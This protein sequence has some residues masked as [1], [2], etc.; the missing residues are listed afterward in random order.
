MTPPLVEATWLAEAGTTDAGPTPT[1]HPISNS[2]FLR[3][4]YGS[5]RED[6]GWTTSFAA[7]PGDAP[8]GVW[9]GSPWP[10]NEAQCALIDRRA[11]A[12]NYYCVAVM[13]PSNPKARNAL[14][15]GRLAVLVADD[16]DPDE[17]MG[18]ASYQLE[19]SPGKYQ[20]G[21][22]LDPED[23]DTRDA[24]LI[25]L[26]LREMVARKVVALDPSGNSHVRYVRL[27][28]GS[29]TKK[30]DSGPFQ[31]K[32][33]SCDLSSVYS[34]ADAVAAF[35]LDLD[36]IRRGVGKAKVAPDAKAVAGDAS[37]LFGAIINP[38]L[39]ERSYHDPL[40]RISA[41]W[42][43][44]G[45]HK[46]TVVNQL[47][48]I[49]MAAKPAV[50]GP[51]MD[52]WQDRVDEIPRMVQG[53][54]KFAPVAGSTDFQWISAA[55]L[56]DKTFPPINW[57]IPNYLPQG[58]TVLAGRPKLGKSWLALD[59]AVA[60]GGGS[61]TLGIK[62]EGGDVLYAALEDTE[63]RLKNRMTKMATAWPE[64]LTFIC[65]MPRADEGGIELVR[66]FLEAKPNPR[67][68]II[69]V[70]AKVRGGKGREEGNY[71]ADYKAVTIWKALADEFGVAIVLVHHTRK[72]P[73]TDKLEM[74][75]GTNGITGAADTLII[76][77]RDG[78]G[79]SIAGRGRD[80][81]EFDLAIQFD[82]SVCRWKALGNASDVRR[83]DERNDIL[84]CLKDAG[85]DG[86]GP[87]DLESLTG[88]NGQN[89]R[90]MLSRMV[91]SGELIKAGRGRYLHPDVMASHNGH[92]VT[93]DGLNVTM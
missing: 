92:K 93:M 50:E 79:A 75:S 86:L 11:A 15:F 24:E 60:V 72:M 53:A 70:L 51:E 42:V 2:D 32:M 54:G 45:M 26:V 8:P 47:R 65:S 83:S 17:L 63:R 9:A 30:R 44:S 10:G 29:N 80:L 16:P 57:V 91:K 41:S 59:W 21:I 58:V 82:K 89:L 4:V 14:N 6:Y 84:S 19:T 33:V 66:S 36:D 7:D 49:M 18:Q 20:V 78:Q 77:D 85:A 37:K 23:P 52:R 90:Q 27:P 55:D 73:S 46:G 35:G 87:K 61:E 88:M 71:E 28:Y 48:A 40:L 1:P 34:L 68:I 62:C 38:D 81:E 67:L 69:D 56:K 43:A 64:R 13:R 76:L 3:A 5:L 22:L 25:G 74:I 12:N 39:D 31:T